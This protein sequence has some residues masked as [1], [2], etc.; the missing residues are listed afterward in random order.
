MK[1]CDEFLISKIKVYTRETNLCYYE[2]DTTVR[3]FH[4]ITKVWHYAFRLVCLKLAVSE[5]RKPAGKVKY[6]QKYQRDIECSNSLLAI[7][8]MNGGGEGARPTDTSDFWMQLTWMK[9]DRHSYPL[10]L[11]FIKEE[12]ATSA[13]NVKFN[14][15]DRNIVSAGLAHI[16]MSFLPKNS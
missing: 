8:P 11:P 14:V 1:W 2:R 12:L 9:T 15:K 4:A 6:K 3:K 16:N 5:A 13:K 10:A 7:G